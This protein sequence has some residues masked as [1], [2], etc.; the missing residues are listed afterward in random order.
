MEGELSFISN[1]AEYAAAIDANSSTISIKGEVMFQNN[2]ASVYG[3]AI[4]THSSNIAMEGEL[5]FHQ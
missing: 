2:S 5:R 3:G 4:A 1:S